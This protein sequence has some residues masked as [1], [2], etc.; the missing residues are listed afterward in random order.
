MIKSINSFLNFFEKIFKR[1]IL[2]CV[3]TIAFPFIMIAFIFGVIGLEK[4]KQEEDE[5]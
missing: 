2:A 5:D 1:C 4:I 3:A